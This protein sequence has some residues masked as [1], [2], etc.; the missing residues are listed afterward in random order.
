MATALALLRISLK[1]ARFPY[2]RGGACGTGIDLTRDLAYK[3]DVSAS[4]FLSLDNSLL[5]EFA[6]GLLEVVYDNGSDSFLSSD[7]R[8]LLILQEGLN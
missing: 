2:L 5:H 4:P 3:L 7:S 1:R 8:K 6:A